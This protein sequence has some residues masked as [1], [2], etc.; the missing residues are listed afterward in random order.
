MTTDGKQ[1]KTIPGA[2][3]LI[4]GGSSHSWVNTSKGE[5]ILIEAFSP[6]RE[7]YIAKA[8]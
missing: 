5:T 4:H 7:D 2:C 8:K 3:W 6:P 1:F